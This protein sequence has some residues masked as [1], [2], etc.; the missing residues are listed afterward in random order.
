MKGGLEERI[1]PL[2][3]IVESSAITLIA[4]KLRYSLDTNSKKTFYKISPSKKHVLVALNT[5][6]MFLVN[7]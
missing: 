1:P 3:Q 6:K 5:P 2:K 7:Y 4:T